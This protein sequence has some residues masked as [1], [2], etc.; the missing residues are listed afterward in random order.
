MKRN[1]KNALKKGR[2]SIK[3][4]FFKSKILFFVLSLKRFFVD[5]S[6]LDK[7]FKKQIL[8]IY[9]EELRRKSSEYCKL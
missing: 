7:V 6:E 1:G 5:V 3:I 4:H 8:N 9:S 2:K